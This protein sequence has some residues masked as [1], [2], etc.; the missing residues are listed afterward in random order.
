MRDLFNINGK[1][2]VITGGTGVLGSVIAT[3]LAGEGASVVILGRRIEPGEALVKEIRNKGGE[4]LFLE[5][6]VLNEEKLT[7]NREEILTRYGRIDVLLNGAGG[8]MSGA[9]IAPERTFFDLDM[10][11]FDQVVKLNLTGS[12]LPS[13]IFLQPMIQQKKGVILNFS[14]MAAFRPMTRVVGYAAAKAGITNFT[15]FLA[16]EVA[17]KFGE[18]IRV[19]AVAPGFFLTEQNRELLTNPDGSY[20]QR[21]KDV[22]RQTPF[23]RMGRPEELCG[24]IHYLVSDASSFVTGS[25][26]TVDGGFNAFA[27]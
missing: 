21:G 10:D 9:N 4:A 7:Q 26:I 19:N 25:T 6:D 15:Q 11:Q 22:I 2:I 24:T 17:T 12:V 14:S 1:V 13:Q 18:G 27:M 5:T 20:T 3:Y 8:N 16:T 23:K